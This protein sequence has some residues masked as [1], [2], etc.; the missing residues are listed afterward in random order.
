M[1]KF[2]LGLICE[3]RLYPIGNDTEENIPFE[4]S[5]VNKKI[6]AGEM[7]LKPNFRTRD[8]ALKQEYNFN[9]AALDCGAGVDVNDRQKN[10]RKSDRSRKILLNFCEGVVY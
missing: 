9:M 1:Q 4:V 2:F 5:I 3:Y 10:Q 7:S 8:C 6:G